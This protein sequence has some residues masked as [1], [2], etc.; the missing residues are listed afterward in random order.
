[1]VPYKTDYEW[2]SDVY[3]SVKPP[4]GHGK[5][6][7]HALGAKTLQ[8]I[9]DHIHVTGIREDLESVVLNPEMIEGLEAAKIPKK[10][11]KLEIQISSRLRRHAGDPLFIALGERLEQLKERHEQ[12]RINSLEFLKQ[13]LQIARET[14]QAEQ[15]VDPQDEQDRAKAALTELFKEAKHEDTPVI[16]E[17]LVDEIDAIV[18]HIRFAGWQATLTG[19]REVQAPCGRACSSTSCTRIRI[20]STGRMRTSSNTIEGRQAGCSKSEPL[21]GNF[22]RGR[23]QVDRFFQQV[24]LG[25]EIAHRSAPRTHQHGMRDGRRFMDFD[26]REQGTVAD[27]GC[28]EEDVAAAGKVARTIDRFQRIAPTAFN[29]GSDVRRHRA[30]KLRLHAAAETTECR[31]CQNAFGALLIPA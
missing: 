19:E 10:L 15:K 16:V 30:A 13:L 17:R 20:C 22:V 14:P 28:G 25:V 29:Q 12:G 18:R 6:L 7:W 8:L 1:M 21:N 27:A 2:L 3:E 26:S 23:T 9:K 5:L 31:G 11:K 24:V 4:S